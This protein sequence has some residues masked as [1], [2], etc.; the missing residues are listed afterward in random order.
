MSR[1]LKVLFLT[2]DFPPA[3]GGIQIWMFELAKRLP[4]ASV[5]VLAP[6]M[7]GSA[8]FDASSGLD[9]RRLRS[10]SVGQFAWLVHL[11]WATVSRSVLDRPDLVVCG[12]VIAGPAALLAKKLLGIRYVVFTHAF[13]IRRRRRRRL[14]TRI[15]RGAALVIANSRFTRDSV[16]SHGVPAERIR[17]VYPGTDTATGDAAA[18]SDGYDAQ[19][20]VILSVSRLVDLYKGHDTVIRAL[21]LIRAKCPGATYVVVGGGPLREFLERLADSLG[22]RQA[23]RFE[24]EVSDTKLAELY[25]RCDVFVQLSREARSG[26]GAE[27]FGIVCLE[28]GLAGKPIVAG[29]S[30]G[31]P[32]AIDDGHTG[33][34]VDPMD[35]ASVTDAIVSLLRD[36]DARGR[37]GSEGRA[38]V[39]RDFSIEQMCERSRALFGEA[40]RA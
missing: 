34:L 6:A 31:L 16:L 23:V 18:T 39:V 26:G 9:V 28:A 8:A 17:I 40:A 36:P 2:W 29:R 22:V 1:P 24:G 7:P 15:L 3:K 20:P 27:G 21:P 35:A 25:R 5:T 14:V 37:M 32:D 30:G 13:E 38:R 4:D 33:L 19:A 10:S 12:H 11:V